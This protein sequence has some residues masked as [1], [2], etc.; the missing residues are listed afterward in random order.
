MREM[1]GA[2]GNPAPRSHFL[3]WLVKPQGCHCTDALGGEKV[4]ERRPPLEALL[5][6][7]FCC[8]GWD[9]IGKKLVDIETG[10]E[11]VSEVREAKE[12]SETNKELA[13]RNLKVEERIIQEGAFKVSELEGEAREKVVRELE[14]I[15]RPLVK[16]LAF[17]AANNPKIL[18]LEKGKRKTVQEFEQG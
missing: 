16:K 11:V 14:E 2:P 17:Q 12:I 13:S 5:I 9:C 3:A 8:I 15:N 7:T 10:K 1:R 6:Q 4:A 18:A